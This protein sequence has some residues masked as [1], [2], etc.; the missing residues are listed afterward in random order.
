M[1]REGSKLY[2]I[3]MKPWLQ[4]NY[5]EIYPTHT[6]KKSVAV[7]SFIRTLKN[8]ICKYMISF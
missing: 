7:E 6:E 5:I 4:D 2:N 1:G 3:S 8:K